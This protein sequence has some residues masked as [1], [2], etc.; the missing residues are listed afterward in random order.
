MKCVVGFPKCGTVSLQHLL[1]QGTRRYEYIYMKN[2]IEKFLKE[3]KD[4]QPVIIV[5][6]PVERIWSAYAYFDQFREMSFA[7]FLEKREI[8]DERL[9]I[10][11]PI[12]QADYWKYIKP[13]LKFNPL[14]YKLEEMKKDPRFKWR[15]KTTKH[16]AINEEER[17]LLIKK[18]NEKGILEKYQRIKELR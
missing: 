13:W 10:D 18:L 16:R 2:G 9:G 3:Q 7:E 11:D 14:I 17:E 4:R 1:G 12:E 8:K 5:R 6:D 15:N